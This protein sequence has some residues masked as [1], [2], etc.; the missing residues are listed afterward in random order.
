M[1]TP[2]ISNSRKRAPRRAP[3]AAPALPEASERLEALGL[4]AHQARLLRRKFGYEIVQ[5]AARWSDEDIATVATYLVVS[6]PLV[7]QWRNSA[8]AS[9]RGTA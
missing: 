8:R 2:R 4:T 1:S 7:R 3:R 9:A 5:Q 6:P